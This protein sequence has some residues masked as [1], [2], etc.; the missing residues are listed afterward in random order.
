MGATPLQAVAAVRLS[1]AAIFGLSDE[2]GSLEPGKGAD[3][4]YIAGNPAEDITGFERVTWV[5]KSGQVMQAVERK[6]A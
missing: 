2:V 4:I 5:M 1:G 3:I 6:S